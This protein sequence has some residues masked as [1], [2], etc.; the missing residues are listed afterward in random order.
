[1]GTGGPFKNRKKLFVQKTGSPHGRSPRVECP[2]DRRGKGPLA[3]RAVSE[4]EASDKPPSGSSIEKFRKFAEE[5]DADALINSLTSKKLLQKQ[6]D[7]PD[8][9]DEYAKAE[10]ETSRGLRPNRKPAKNV[11]GKRVSESKS[12]G[13]GKAKAPGTMFIVEAILCLPE[14]IIDVENHENDPAASA[15]AVELGNRYFALPKQVRSCTNVLSL[16]SLQAYRKQGLAA[17]DTTKGF[18]F[19]KEWTK[20][21]MSEKLSEEL[22]AIRL[23]LE[24]GST[25]SRGRPSILFCTRRDRRIQLTG[26]TIPNGDAA[27]QYCRGARS[28]WRGSVMIFSTITYPH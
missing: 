12:K 26:L 25:D 10:A 2:T 5:E 8:S 23:L 9:E 17:V 16:P 24:E 4:D 28:G 3:P 11:G 7:T 18:E 6:G 19:N 20:E 1:M 21:E 27:K 13:K 14:G 15:S 22:P